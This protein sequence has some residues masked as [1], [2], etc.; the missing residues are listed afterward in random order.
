MRH[1]G[2]AELGVIDP[3]RFIPA[4]LQAALGI[5]DSQATDRLDKVLSLIAWL[6]Q[7]HRPAAEPWT[8]SRRP[9]WRCSAGG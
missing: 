3:D 2:F 7:F 9:N 5:G 4:L 8:T 6:E 1:P